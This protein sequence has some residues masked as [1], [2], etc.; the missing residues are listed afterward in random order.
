MRFTRYMSKYSFQQWSAYQNGQWIGSLSWQS[1]YAQADWLWLAASPESRSRA[2][3][4]L[5]PGAIQDLRSGKRISINRKL[6]INFPAG[7]SQTAL[8]A[9]GFNQHQTLIW[10]KKD[11][12]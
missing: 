10:M 5:L 4:A 2:A 12:K 6:A 1:S 9:A 3:A 11:L 8:E 7:D